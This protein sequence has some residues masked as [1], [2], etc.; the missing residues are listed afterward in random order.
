MRFILPAQTSM[1]SWER[2]SPPITKVLREG[3][4][5]GVNIRATVGVR[6]AQLTFI[7]LIAL[8]RSFRRS[9]FDGMQTQ[10]PYIK[11]IMFSSM[12]TSNAYEANW[13]TRVEGPKLSSLELVREVA[14]R[15]R[16]SKMEPLGVPVL[17][18]E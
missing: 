17:P 7:F 11:L 1:M 3:T 10:A 13:M 2:G 5:A 15:E 4:V 9:S 8:A 14:Q 6:S 12:A 18:D 16:C